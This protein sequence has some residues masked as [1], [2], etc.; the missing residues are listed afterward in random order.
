M[1][2]AVCVLALVAVASAARIPTLRGVEAI[3]NS[4]LDAAKSALKATPCQS[5]AFTP[6]LTVPDAQFEPLRQLLV[7]SAFYAMQSY[8]PEEETLKGCS[9]PACTKAGGLTEVFVQDLPAFTAY[10]IA[11]ITPDKSTVLVSFRGSKSI[12]DWIRNLAVQPGALS[13]PPVFKWTEKEAPNAKV[14]AAWLNAYVQAFRTPR[15]GANFITK[16]VAL[17]KKYPKATLLI[18]G[19]SMAAAYAQFS[20]LDLQHELQGKVP[21][22]IL[23]FGGVRVGN[24]AFATFVDQ[25]FPAG[26]FY[27][28]VNYKD[29]APHNPS[30]ESGFRHAG[31]EIWVSG[32]YTAGNTLTKKDIRMCQ[33]GG[34]DKSCAWAT[35]GG[36][37]LKAHTSYMESLNGKNCVSTQS[38]LDISVAGLKDAIMRRATETVDNAKKLFHH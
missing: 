32:D 30:V 13:F 4:G 17:T 35:H 29:F 6:S 15:T 12:Q 28:V 36:C 34:E 5:P 18:V 33:F 26:T 8:C 3:L 14:H 21:M 24:A 1:R 27:R 25:K 38:L 23:T 2:W 22:K 9:S 10:G 20:A 16:I 7:K 31:T 19:H 11:G 37:S